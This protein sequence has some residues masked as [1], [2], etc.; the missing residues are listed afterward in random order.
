MF[1]RLRDRLRHKRNEHAL[2]PTPQG[3][4]SKWLKRRIDQAAFQKNRY[5]ALK[6]SHGTTGSV[7][8]SPTSEPPTEKSHTEKHLSVEKV[9][10]DESPME[11][12]PTEKSPSPGS[13]TKPHLDPV[14]MDVMAY[15]GAVMT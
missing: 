2:E 11:E 9:P 6:D 12:P 3:T 15:F 1:R 10:T 14:A 5:R 7:N 4:F 13:D 8:E